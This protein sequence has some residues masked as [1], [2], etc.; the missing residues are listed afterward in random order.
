MAVR[1]RLA[2]LLAGLSIAADLGFGLPPEQAMRSCLIGTA[3]ARKLDLPE[4]E[5]ADTFYATLLLHVG[6]TAL[7]HETAAFAGDDRGF[8]G[9]VARTNVA[10]ARETFGRLLPSVTRGL[11]PVRRTQ[12]AA[13][14]VARGEAFGRLHDT[15]SCE[16]ASA[17]ARRIGLGDGV[18]R[19]LFE[20]FERWKGGWAP[21]GL[22]G[23][24]IALPA[25]VAR[26]ASEAAIFADLGDAA[27]VVDALVGGGL[28]GALRGEALK[29]ALAMRRRYV[30][31]L[32][33]DLPTGLHPQGGMIGEV[34]PADITLAFGLPRPGL[35]LAG[36]AP[37]VGDL[38]LADALRGDLFR[39]VG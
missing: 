37:L 26:L 5:V 30:P 6:C 10:D 14:L 2:D 22:A 1:L 7:A 8:L 17:T 34:L 16:V 23:E 35:F 11:P 32:S 3:L 29:I 13:R 9:E 38:Y 28:H 19:A 25:R 33:L 24:E 20:I 12:L 36:L 39:L 4:R 27:L 18:Q 31:V 15:G 21:Q